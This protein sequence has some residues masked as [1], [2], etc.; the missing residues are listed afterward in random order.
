M[1][2]HSQT[3]TDSLVQTPIPS[4]RPHFGMVYA[5]F[6]FYTFFGCYFY[7]FI[8]LNIL[9]EALEVLLLLIGGIYLSEN[10]FLKPGK[11]LYIW[12]AVSLFISATLFSFTPTLSGQYLLISFFRSSHLSDSS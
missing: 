1:T 6:V 11:D 7:E 12:V 2:A 10:L 4:T 9:D 3:D 8:G 5:Y